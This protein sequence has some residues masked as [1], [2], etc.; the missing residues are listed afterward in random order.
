LHYFSHMK[1]T[2]NTTDKQAVQALRISSLEISTDF[3]SSISSHDE[4]YDAS[5]ILIELAK[6]SIL[7]PESLRTLAELLERIADDADRL[8]TD[9]EHEAHATESLC[10]LVSENLSTRYD[11]FIG[12]G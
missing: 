3:D 9:D 6:N 2:Q 10:E 5:K 8:K 7:T 1:S 12:R 4:L 11:K